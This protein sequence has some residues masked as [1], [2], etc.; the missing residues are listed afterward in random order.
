[1]PRTRA[2]EPSE[3]AAARPRLLAP[4]DVDS[5][6]SKILEAAYRRLAQEG[7]AALSMREIAKDAGVNHALINYHFRTKDQLVIEVLDAANRRLLARQSAMYRG[8]GSFA[9]K[10]SEARRFYESDLASGFVRVQAELWAASLANAELREKFLPRVLAWKQLVLDA[11][12][13]AMAA[14]ESHG[15]TLPPAITAEVVACWISQ[16]WLGMEWADLLDVKQERAMHGAALDA[17]Q[18]LLRWLDTQG[19]GGAAAHAATQLRTGKAPKG[20]KSNTHAKPTP[21]TRH[22]AKTR[23][24]SKPRTRG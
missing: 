4:A 9:E 12:R 16:F 18:W 10:W 8:P 20:A 14:A 22:A 3:A 1:M 15:V 2:A 24:A 13:E 19:N 11:V 5:T 6:K 17:V 7:Y 21:T 23:T